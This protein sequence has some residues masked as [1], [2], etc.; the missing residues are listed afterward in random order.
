MKKIFKFP[1]RKTS[2]IDASDS[3]SIVTTASDIRENEMS[4]FHKA[5]WQGDM[6]K[7]EQLVKIV[8]INQVDKQNRSVLV[9]VCCLS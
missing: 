2:S 9:Q 8:D 4:K 6:L 1:K 7:L 5:S 3:A